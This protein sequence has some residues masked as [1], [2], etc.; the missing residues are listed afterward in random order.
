VRGK[1][2]KFKHFNEGELKKESVWAKFAY[3]D[4]DGKEY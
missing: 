2:A 1:N 3:T 4:S